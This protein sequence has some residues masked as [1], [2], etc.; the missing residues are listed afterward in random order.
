MTTDQ[1]QEGPST[2]QTGGPEARPSVE[3][4]QPGSPASENVAEN[5]LGD[6]TLTTYRYLRISLIAVLLL[7]ASAVVVQTVWS[8]KGWPP[9]W[10]DPHWETSISYYYWTPVRAV[11]VGALMAMGVS[12]VVLKADNEVEDILLNIAGVLAPVVALVP[13]PKHC[14]PDG[15][16]CIRPDWPPDIVEGIR[17]N[18]SALFISATLALL[19][20]VVIALRS[21]LAED[22]EADPAEGGRVPTR[23]WMLGR[24]DSLCV[25]RCWL[26]QWS[27]SIVTAMTFRMARISLP[28]SPC[29]GAS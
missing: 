21:R 2:D 23:I 27:G 9:L 12:M 15:D 20:F 17:N 8:N 26:R 19:F 4:A 22:D 5:L 6:Q 3:S 14:V 10:G 7:L 29:L 28:P 25:S 18:I 13:T 16:K 1:R 24:S 11:F